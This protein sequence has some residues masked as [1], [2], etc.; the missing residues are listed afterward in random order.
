MSERTNAEI[1][2]C[3]SSSPTAGPTISV[4]T[5]LKFPRF[6]LRSAA[7]TACATTLSE[8]PC[9]APTCGT[10]TITWRSGASPYV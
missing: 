9:S 6:P 1:P 3:V 5:T 4:P 7:S 8:A 2:F 10:R